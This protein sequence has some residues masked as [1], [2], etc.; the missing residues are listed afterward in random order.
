ML[1]KEQIES[2]HTLLVRERPMGTS[3]AA[4]DELC[5]LAMLGLE[6]DEK[7]ERVG[8]AV[9]EAG[10]PLIDFAIEAAVDIIR[11]DSSGFEVNDIANLCAIV[12]ALEA[13]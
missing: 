2:M 11:N 8:R 9:I 4:V 7:A 1:M 3:V 10:E 12:H 6:R 13:P 5:R